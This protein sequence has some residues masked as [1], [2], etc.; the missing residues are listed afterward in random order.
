MKRNLKGMTTQKLMVYTEILTKMLGD[1]DDLGMRFTYA[2]GDG[3]ITDKEKEDNQIKLLNKINLYEQL[4]IQCVTEI[5]NRFKDDMKVINGPSDIDDMLR[6]IKQ[7]FP[8]VMYGSKAEWDLHVK[9][10]EEMLK[11]NEKK[12]VETE[13][14]DGVIQQIEEDASKKKSKKKPLKKV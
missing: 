1:L 6:G 2:A 14:G 8:M 11:A 12:K 13:A 5:N 10:G 4:R 9:E 7:K 3:R